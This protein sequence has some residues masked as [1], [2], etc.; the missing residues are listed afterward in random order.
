MKI[1]FAIA[2]YISYALQAYVPIEIIWNTYLKTKLEQSN[3]K[4]LIEYIMR[5]VIVIL[6]CES[7]EKEH[8]LAIAYLLYQALWTLCKA[9]NRYVL[10]CSMAA[11]GMAYRWLPTHDSGSSGVSENP[12][13]I[14]FKN[15]KN[16]KGISSLI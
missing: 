1:A 16:G 15:Q 4:L 11:Y 7:L 3:K 13:N 10:N 2:I 12:C 8:K 6:T 9:V 5:T 14:K